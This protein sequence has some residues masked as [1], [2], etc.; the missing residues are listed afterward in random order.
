M[1]KSKDNAPARRLPWFVLPLI[2]ACFALDQGTKVWVRSKIDPL[3]AIGVIPGCFDLV[4]VGNTGAAFGMF[5]DGNAGFIALSAVAIV[6]LTAMAWRGFF[7]R[8]ILGLA[9]GLLMGGIWGN[10][11]DRILVG[12]VTDF[13]DFYIG[14]HHWPAFNVADSCICVAAA[15]LVLAEIFTKREGGNGGSAAGDLDKQDRDG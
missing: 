15:L 11:L 8:P 10:S 6:A 1:M 14:D 4:H 5:K 9:G 3:E 12:H 13:L 2:V 7:S